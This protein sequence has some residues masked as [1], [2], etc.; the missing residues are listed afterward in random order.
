MWVHQVFHG[1]SCNGPFWW[2]ICELYSL[3]ILDINQ[4]STHSVSFSV[5]DQELLPQKSRMM[6]GNEKL[7]DYLISFIIIVYAFHQ[8]WD[9]MLLR[10]LM[11]LPSILMGISSS[12]YRDIVNDKT[13]VML[14]VK[15]FPKWS[16]NYGFLKWEMAFK[17]WNGCVVGI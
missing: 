13:I 17:E 1:I 10:G 3:S 12:V 5:L 14:I 8:L 11:L 4:L 7:P 15:S 6:H 2:M 16:C 9:W